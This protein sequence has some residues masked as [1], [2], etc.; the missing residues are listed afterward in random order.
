MKVTKTRELT[1]RDKDGRSLKHY[2]LH[3]DYEYETPMGTAKAIGSSRITSH[4]NSFEFGKGATYHYIVGILEDGT[5]IR[6]EVHKVIDL[7]RVPEA[8]ADEMYHDL[9]DHRPTYAKRNRFPQA[10]NPGW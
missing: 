4:I 10:S 8:T 5:V 9:F 3:K 6:T 2:G 1:I 7:M